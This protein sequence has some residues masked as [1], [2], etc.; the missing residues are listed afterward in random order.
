MEDRRVATERAI[1]FI[2]RR[3]NEHEEC[4]KGRDNGLRTEIAVGSL[5][6]K[7]YRPSAIGRQLISKCYIELERMKLCH[8]I[9]RHIRCHYVMYIC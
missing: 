8:T 3:L 9:T 4:Q 6:L 7:E 2:R 5:V 1:E